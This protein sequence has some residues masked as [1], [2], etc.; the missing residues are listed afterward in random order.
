MNKL[1]GLLCLVMVMVIWSGCDKDDKE[2]GDL[3][4]P[5]ELQIVSITDSVGIYDYNFINPEPTDTTYVR[6]YLQKDSVFLADGSFDKMEVDTVYY[7]GKT[8]KLYTL[9]TILLPK[10]KNRLYIRLSSN[11]RWTAPTIP[12]SSE[13]ATWIR[14]AKVG[15]VGDAIIDYNIN[16]RSSNPNST[17]STRRKVQTQYITTQDSTIMYKLQF[18]QKSMIEE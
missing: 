13:R 8:A 3:T 1:K 10:Y 7:E 12:F 18:S 17:V 15:G 4:L 6:Y 16:P 2:F 14:N 5:S 9:P 11:A